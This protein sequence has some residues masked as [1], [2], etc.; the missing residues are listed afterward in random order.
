MVSILRSSKGFIAPRAHGYVLTFLGE[1]SDFVIQLKCYE[2]WGVKVKHHRWNTY[3][4]LFK[5]APECAIVFSYRCTC[6]RLVGIGKTGVVNTVALVGPTASGKSYLALQVARS[7]SNVEIVSVDSMQV[8]RGMDIGTAKPTAEDQADVLH[9]LIDLVD[10]DQTFSV[11]EYQTAFATAVT[12]IHRRGNHALVVGGTGLYLRAVLDN[13]VPPGRFPTARATIEDETNTRLLYARLSELDPLAASRIEPDNRRRIVRA[14]EVT[15]GSGRPFSS[16]GPGLQTFGKPRFP[17]FALAV[18][19]TDLAI[20]INARVQ[21]ML[22][23][24]LIDEVQTL[25]T[26]FDFSPTARQAIGYKEV[27]DMLAADSETQK[28]IRGELAEQI[29][30]RTRKYARR[31]R[32]WFRRD[33][34]ITWMR[35]QDSH[36]RELATK[37]LLNAIEGDAS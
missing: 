35:Y 5:T 23:V 21:Q 19:P 4:F 6:A 33:P 12:A 9:H 7:L 2:R 20:S 32:A 8:Y 34:R 25:L 17:C 24:G 27:L 26:R 29:A 13:L 15:I 37:T 1:S 11:T 10:P 16:F 14:L 28:S 30:A 36:D 31:Q 3:A 22:A 18:E